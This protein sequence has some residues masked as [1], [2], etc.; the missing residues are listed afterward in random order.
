[1][2][3]RWDDLNTVSLRKPVGSLAAWRTQS[4]VS[5]SIIRRCLRM[6][7]EV[8]VAAPDVMVEEDYVTGFSVAFEGRSCLWMPTLM[9]LS[10]PPQ[11][12]SNPDLW[13]FY[14]FLS[15]SFS[16]SD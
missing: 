16:G 3:Q 4:S 12:I 1:M 13:T 5:S 2:I 7:E 8:E 10:F 9:H 6:A 11:H 15:G 14:L